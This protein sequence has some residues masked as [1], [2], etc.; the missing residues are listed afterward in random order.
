MTLLSTLGDGGGKRQPAVTQTVWC[1]HALRT[2]P[3]LTCDFVLACVQTSPIM[4]CSHIILWRHALAMT[5]FELL[6]LYCPQ[7]APVSGANIDIVFDPHPKV[8]L[9]VDL[10]FCTLRFWMNYSKIPSLYIIIYQPLYHYIS[11]A[12][13]LYIIH[14]TL[15]IIRYIIIY[16]SYIIIYHSYNIIY[17]S[18][19]HFISFVISLYIIVI[20]LYIIILHYISLYIVDLKRM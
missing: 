5:S 13:S 10:S 17:H 9:L 8:Q 19:Y 7:L 3:L 2:G 20:S 15:Y 14:I 16:H 4:K 1:E 11:F 12:I 18:L 6:G